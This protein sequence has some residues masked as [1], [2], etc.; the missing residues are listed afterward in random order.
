MLVV[1][2]GVLGLSYVATYGLVRRALA[3]QRADDL[4]EAGDGAA[5]LCAGHQ[6]RRTPPAT[7]AACAPAH[8][9]PGRPRAAERRR[10]R[11]G[12]FGRGRPPRAAHPVR[13]PPRPPRRGRAGERAPGQHRLPRRADRCGRARGGRYVVVATDTV[14][15]SVLRKLFPLLLLAGLVVLG[16]AFAVAAWLARR[17]T[18]PIGEIER[19]GAQAR[20]RRP[21]GAHRCGVLHRRRARGARRHAQRHGRPAGA[22]TRQRAGVPAVDLARP[23]HSAHVDPGV[24]RSARRRHARRRRPRRPQTRGDR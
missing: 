15:M 4:A 3:E 16:L 7:A 6:C 17:L 8:R 10:R 21:L 1:A 12:P 23:P 24:R 20:D 14:D 18:R 2:F 9:H 22:R 5:R 13:H 19:A 11:H